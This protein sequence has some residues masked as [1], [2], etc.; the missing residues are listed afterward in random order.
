MIVLQPDRSFA[1]AQ[2]DNHAIMGYIFVTRERVERC[3]YLGGVLTVILNEVKDLKVCI[4]V[5]CL[6]TR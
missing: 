6:A 1:K 3:V 2:D 5:D 4:A